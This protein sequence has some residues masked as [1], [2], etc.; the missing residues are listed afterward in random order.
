MSK[1]EGPAWGY[2]LEGGE[3]VSKIFEDGKLPQGWQDSP[4]KLKGAKK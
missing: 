4:A 3:V 1:T 2:K